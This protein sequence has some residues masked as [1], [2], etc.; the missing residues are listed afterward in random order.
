MRHL[1][2]GLEDSAPQSHTRQVDFAGIMAEQLGVRQG[3]LGALRAVSL[4]MG[5]PTGPV[6]SGEGHG[7]G[8][9]YP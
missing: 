6:R 9:T 8:A 1:P 4:L 7:T 3:S 5:W 2:I